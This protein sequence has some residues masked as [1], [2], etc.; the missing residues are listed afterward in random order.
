MNIWVHG[1]S[2]AAPYRRPSDEQDLEQIVLL[3]TLAVIFLTDKPG[4][5]FTLEQLLAE[6]RSLLP[7]EAT[8]EETD[9]RIVLANWKLLKRR[10]GGKYVMR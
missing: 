7:K 5:E 8:L 4:D 9:V 1:S 10:A 2:I 3:L 6:A